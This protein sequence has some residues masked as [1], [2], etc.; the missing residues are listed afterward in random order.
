MTSGSIKG[1]IPISLLDWEGAVAAVLF[2]GGCN[3]NCP[4]CHNPELVNNPDKMKTVPFK[5][6][7]SYLMNKKG[8]IDGVVITGGEP[9]LAPDLADIIEEVRA[10]GLPVKLDTNGSNPAILKKLLAQSLIDYIA[11][12]IKTVFERYQDVTKSSID[13][14]KIIESINLILR[15]NIRHE[16]RTTAYPEAVTLDDLLSI[17]RYLGKLNGQRYAIQQFKNERVL[18]NE[19]EAVKPYHMDSL[20]ETALSCN[21]YIPTIVR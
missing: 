1:Y 14:E 6:I 11:M 9:T 7:K 20:D 5:D 15:S 21:N 13:E 3:F 19:A 16:F 4:F 12:D 17:A 2:T 8:W 18:L 10:L